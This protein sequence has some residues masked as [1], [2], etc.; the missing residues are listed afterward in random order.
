MLMCTV[1]VSIQ[2]LT[3]CGR[4]RLVPSQNCCGPT[5]MF[6]EAGTVRSI[7]MASG[8]LTDRTA[9]SAAGPGTAAVTGS[10]SP[11]PT[12]PG[13]HRRQLRAGT[14]QQ[15]R[16]CPGTDVAAGGCTP[17]ATIDRG[18]SFL[19]RGEGPGVVEELVLQGLM[20]ALHLA[21]VVGESGLVSSWRMPL[22][23]QI[24]SNSTSAGR[25][26]PNLPVNC[27]PLSVSTS[28]GMP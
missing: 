12:A 5:V 14:C 24:R 22:R 13:R 27:L 4:C 2:K 18:L 26:L 8:Q 23:R 15:G 11:E 10:R 1:V 6:P 9:G 21:V 16:P 19:D 28:S 25:G 20:P 17:A 3:P 7:S